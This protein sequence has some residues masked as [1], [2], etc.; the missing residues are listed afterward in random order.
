MS[1][2]LVV[3]G[4]GGKE[5]LSQNTLKIFFCVTSWLYSAANKRK[6]HSLRITYFFEDSAEWL[7]RG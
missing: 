5:L 2:A 7:G 6:D 4:G 1:V 3:W